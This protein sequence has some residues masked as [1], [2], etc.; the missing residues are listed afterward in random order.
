MWLREL[1]LRPWVSPLSV[2]IRSEKSLEIT[3]GAVRVWPAKVGVSTVY[4]ELG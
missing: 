3:A 2:H 1:T 4:I